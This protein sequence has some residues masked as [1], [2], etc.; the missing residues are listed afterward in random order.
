M[1]DL[2]PSIACALMLLTIAVPA[3][4]A[5]PA[6]ADP[7]LV[8]WFES[9][10]RPDGAGSCCATTDCRRVQSRLGRGGYEVFL[11][12]LW[13]KIPSN[14][15]LHRENPTGEAVVCARGHLIFCFVPAPET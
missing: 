15:V 4:S 8:P 5:P 7:S 3:R 12:G 1:R 9:L 11:D 10:Q 6:D 14:R 2:R 13:V